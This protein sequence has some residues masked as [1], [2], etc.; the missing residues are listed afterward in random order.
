MLLRKDE[1]RVMRCI[2]MSYKQESKVLYSESFITICISIIIGSIIGTLFGWGTFK[3]I[4]WDATNINYA[5]DWI[6]ILISVA[7]LVVF[8]VLTTFLSREDV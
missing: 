2:G 3:I 5:V 6:S 1:F 7:A 8:S 4:F